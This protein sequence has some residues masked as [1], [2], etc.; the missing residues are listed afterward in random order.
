MSSVAVIYGS[1]GLVF[2]GDFTWSNL[3]DDPRGLTGSEFGMIR[4]AQELAKRHEVVLYTQS[5]EEQTADGIEVRPLSALKDHE[6]DVA[7]S[8]NEPDQLRDARAKRRICEFWLNGFTFCREGFHE[9]VDAFVSPSEPHRQKVIN[10]WR[11]V[12]T[13]MG[14]PRAQYE[15][16]PEKWHTIELGCDPEAHH[17]ESSVPG[18]TVYISSPDRGLHH[19]LQR[20]PR[21]KRAVPHAELRVFYRLQAWIDGFKDTAFFPPIEPLRHRALYIEE[22]LRRMRERGGLARWGVTIYDSVSRNRVAKELSEASVLA[23][24]CDTTQWSEGFSCSVLEA[25]AAGTVP[26][27]TDC[28][29]LGEVYL[30]SGAIIKSCDALDA[31]EDGVINVLEGYHEER[32]VQLRAFAEARTWAKHVE[33]LEELF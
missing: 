24:P 16:D 3:W 25:C 31:W 33:R 32:R 2:R 10:D 1:A 6:H 26:V 29:A 13:V 30:D 4:I 15:P 27:I 5:A 9:H 8:I 17:P 23:Y 19:L 18:R 14:K 20:W 28:D 11:D 21:I 12:Q 22:A 7:V